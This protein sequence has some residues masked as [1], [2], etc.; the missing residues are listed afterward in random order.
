MAKPIVEKSIYV[1]MPDTP[2]VALNGARQTGKTTVVRA[3]GR[4][5]ARNTARWTIPPCSHRGRN[6]SPRHCDSS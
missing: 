3:I 1:A 2:V 6:Q 5:R 4:K